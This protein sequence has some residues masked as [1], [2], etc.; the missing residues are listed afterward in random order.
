MGELVNG[1]NTA[2][3]A[4]VAL[5]GSLLIQSSVL[6]VL[7]AALDLLLRKRVKAVVRHWIWLLVLV[8][9]LLPPSLSLPTSLVSWVGSQLPQTALVSLM[10]EPV[11]SAAP[12]RP[13]DVA[14]RPQAV[15]EPVSE[16]APLPGSVGPADGLAHVA[17]PGP[18][19]LD[20][21]R[22]AHGGAPDP[23]GLVRP[24][25]DEA[26]AGGPRQPAGLTGTVPPADGPARQRGNPAELPVGQPLRVRVAPAGDPDAGANGATIAD[27]AV[28]VRARP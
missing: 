20:G 24:R 10:P 1:L 19:G 6:I 28:A 13:G 8:K 3:Q 17:G 5:A 21:G 7:L 15:T 9:L 22:P 26:V 14:A 4:F 23:A 18:A 25:V 11:P 16:A 27:A 12:L 2:G